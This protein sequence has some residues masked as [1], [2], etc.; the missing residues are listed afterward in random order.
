MAHLH[1]LKAVFFCFAVIAL[2]FC[3][4]KY[5]QIIKV[6]IWAIMST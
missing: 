2:A 3:F 1:R 4:Y 5:Y 6:L